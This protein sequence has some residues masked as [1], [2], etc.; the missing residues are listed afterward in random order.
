MLK[1]LPTFM[2]LLSL[3]NGCQWS[4][5]AE[6][7]NTNGTIF[8]RDGT[9]NK[10]TV[11]L[12]EDQYIIWGFV[13][14]SSCILSVLNVVYMNDGLSDTCNITVYVDGGQLVGSFD[15]RAQSHLP[16][17][18]G[19]IGEAVMSSGDH[20]I[21]LTATN[22][23]EYGIE[24]DRMT[25]EMLCTN[26]MST[27]DGACPNAQ[28]AGLENCKVSSNHD[29][30][31]KK[32]IIGLA[33]EIFFAIVEAILLFVT[34][35]FYCKKIKNGHSDDKHSV[36]LVKFNVN[37]EEVQIP[38]LPETNTNDELPVPEPRRSTR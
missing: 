26:G 15:T 9:S 36:A 8:Q 38:L 30:W 1:I 24:I 20:T 22:M 34:L 2:L 27:S 14:E 10:L 17:S 19:P 12:S 32:L 31:D 6:H 4:V 35:Y 33:F 13:T 37:N 16:V 25:L 3:S 11:R 28:E 7:G 5:E 23:N 18:S 29:S 21:K